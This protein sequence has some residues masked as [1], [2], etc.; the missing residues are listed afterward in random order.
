M[1]KT[2]PWVTIINLLSD[3]VVFN[4]YDFNEF[5]Q[6][7][8]KAVNQVIPVDAC[9]IYFYDRERKELTLVGSKKK[10]DELLGH[11]TMKKGEG[12]TGWVVAHGRTVVL[13]REAYKDPRF[14]VFEEL[15]ED[16]FESF[17]SVPIFDEQG[18][19][20]VINL[21]SREPYSFSKEEVLGL[22]A[23]VKIISSGFASILL[24][25]KVGQLEDRL[26]SRQ[27]IEEAKG[28]L[29]SV[30]KMSE[31]EAYHFLRREAMQKRKTM[32]EIAEA[33]V[34]VLK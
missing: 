17:L 13:D 28:I 6:K 4:T 12:I 3:L 19:V 34:M 33:V 31:S 25:R 18:V 16:R 30:R 20:G 21:Q 2:I 8:I 23:V 22:E 32:K 5:L 7:L 1:N 27:V 26:Q 24:E 10:H 29:M 14:K 15:P 11:I 9:L